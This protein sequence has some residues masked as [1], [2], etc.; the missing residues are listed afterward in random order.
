MLYLVGVAAV[1]SD[2][3][4]WQLGPISGEIGEVVGHVPGFAIE[5]SLLFG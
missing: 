4:G 2:P 3:E 5:A 1:G